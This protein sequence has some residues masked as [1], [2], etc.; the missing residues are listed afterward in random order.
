MDRRRP[1]QSK[2]TTQRKSNLDSVKIL[3]GIFQ[4]KT[5]GTPISIIIMNEDKKIQRLRNNKR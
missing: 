4:G 2:F 1:G 5:T 3:S